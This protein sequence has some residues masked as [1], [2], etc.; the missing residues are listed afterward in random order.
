MFER[1][2]GA[3]ERRA[4]RSTGPR[5][6]GLVASALLIVLLPLL[7]PIAQAAEPPNI[8][9]AA[10]IALRILAG[11]RPA[12]IATPDVNPNVDMLRLA[13]AAALG[14]Q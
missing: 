12:T 3:F 4:G 11:E 13:S 5:V 6:R 1:T 8:E 2:Y 9:N 7:C 14:C 10:K